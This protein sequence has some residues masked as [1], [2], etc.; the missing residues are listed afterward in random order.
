MSSFLQQHAKATV[1][2]RDHQAYLPSDALAGRVRLVVRVF[3]MAGIAATAQAQAAAVDGVEHYRRGA[4]PWLVEA[5]LTLAELPWLAN[6]SATGSLPFTPKD[7]TRRLAR[8]CGGVA[9]AARRPRAPVGALTLLDPQLAL[10]I[11]L[12]FELKAEHFSALLAGPLADRPAGTLRWSEG[13]WR[14]LSRVPALE[15][16]RSSVGSLTSK[17]Q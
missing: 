12:P 8:L 9:A 13:E 6:R 15:C 14:L 11:E 3:A 17:V 2:C 5:R 1:V 16:R 7:A 10:A 4:A